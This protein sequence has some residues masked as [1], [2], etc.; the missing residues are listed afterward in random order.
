MLVELVYV[1]SVEPLETTDVERGIAAQWHNL[2][3]A[4]LIE[5]RDLMKQS[6][7]VILSHPENLLEVHEIIRTADGR[8]F[9]SVNICINSDVPINEAVF[10]VIDAVTNE[11]ACRIFES[12]RKN[13]S[14]LGEHFVDQPKIDHI[15]DITDKFLQNHRGLKYHKPIKL[16][17]KDSCLT[18]SGR[19]ARVPDLPPKSEKQTVV[20]RIISMDT[21][22]RTVGIQGNTAKSISLI[23]YD[24]KLFFR[25][26]KGMLGEPLIGSFDVS[27]IKNRNK[28]TLE[29]QSISSEEQ[30]EDGD[31]NLM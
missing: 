26:L 30:I 15:H 12:E 22:G 14:L 4:P 29:L 24:E 16:G 9:A 8:A 11:V 1:E 31:F 25:K 6:L 28:I 17:T 3:W 18:F 10:R 7:S 2:A 19:L 27:V 13:I 21:I 20:G 23:H 5:I